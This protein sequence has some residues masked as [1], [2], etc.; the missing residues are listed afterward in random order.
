MLLI[1]KV[2]HEKVELETSDAATS[3]PN[4]IVSRAAEKHL[5]P[6]AWATGCGH[7]KNP[8]KKLAVTPCE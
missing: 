3:V 4:A 1:L 2:C 6:V 5:T 7:D 8:A